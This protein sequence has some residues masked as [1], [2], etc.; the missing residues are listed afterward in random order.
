[1]RKILTIYERNWETDRK[2]NSQL[3]VDF[4]F[5]N[6]IATE[7]LDGMNIRVTIRNGV[8]VRSEKRRN[9]GKLQKQQGIID[10][11]Y[12]DIDEHSSQDKWLVNAIRNTNFSDVPD[13]E[14][15]GEA[16]GTNIQ[17]NPLKL[18][19]NKVFLFSLPTWRQ[20]ICLENVPTS[21]EDLRAYLKSQ[22]SSI[23]SDCLIEGIV[24]H[25][26]NGDMVKIKRRDFM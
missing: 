13:G 19:G 24:W 26:P 1:M 5:E 18:E 25:H 10:P 7:K 15:P 16:I 11:W 9:P 12:V 17:G 4:D 20:K 6:A 2:V 23:G 14:W 22:K 8:V 3:I 21:F